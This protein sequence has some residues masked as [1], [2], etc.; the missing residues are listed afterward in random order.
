MNSRPFRILSLDEGGIRG[1]F[2]AAFLAELE[3]ITGR[4]L[5]EHFDLLVGTSTGSIIVLGLASG[6]SAAEILEF[7]TEYCPS[8]FPTPS[9][10]Q[11]LTK[12]TRWFFRPKYGNA[13]LIAALRQTFHETRIGDL[14]VPVC[15]PSYEVTVGWPRLF[16]TDHHEK[17]Q[18]DNGKLVW[19]VAAASSAAPT[20]FPAFQF[21]PNDAYVDGGIWANNPV[22][23]GIHEALKYCGQTL[24]KLS[25]LSVGTGSRLPRLAPKKA[26]SMGLI[27]WGVKGRIIELVFQ[28]QSGSAHNVAALLLPDDRYLRIETDLDESIPLDQYDKAAVLIERGRNRARQE[29]EKIKARFL[30]WP[31]TFQW[32]R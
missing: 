17:L 3:K 22:L 16:K 10:R 12:T 8:L 7:Y 6:K 18:L 29:R 11:F 27:S 5:V 9:L 13:P 26:K 24:E 28:A 32:P 30:Q 19:Q 14:K 15:V 23:V 4:K 20:Y 2:P 1:L 21:D 25:I 31:R